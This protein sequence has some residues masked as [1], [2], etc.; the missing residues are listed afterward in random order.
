M[1]ARLEFCGNYIE[2]INFSYISENRQP[3]DPL[4]CTFDIKI[5]S[6]VFS[7]IA[8]GCEY[9]HQE[10]EKFISS[11]ED[12]INFRIKKTSL[13]ET[14]YGNRIDLECDR[15]GHIRVSGEIYGDACS[16]Y[17][18]FEFDTD[19]TAFPPFINALKSL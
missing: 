6:G 18:K 19:Q 9:D 2:I 5:R 11:L 4:Y 13:F 12:L 10:W 3:G 15:T 14:G 7:G 8:D 1:G 16:H 17:L